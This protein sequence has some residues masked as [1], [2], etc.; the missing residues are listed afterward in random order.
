MKYRIDRFTRQ[1][2]LLLLMS[3]GA[4][5]SLQLSATVNAETIRIPL[6]QQGKAW[7][8]ETPRHGITKLEVEAQFGAP[9]DR[10]GPVGEPPI[11]TWDYERFTVY[12]EGDHVIHSVVKFD[13]ANP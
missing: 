10:T 5:I 11:Y 7:Q 4:I 3:L 2:L 6:G 1:P 13:P 8:V 9:Q 12:F